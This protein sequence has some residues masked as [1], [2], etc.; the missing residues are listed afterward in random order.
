[1][2]SRIDSR[3][4]S[5]EGM[6]ALFGVHTYLHQHTDLTK[7]L[8]DLVFLRTSQINGCAHC[9][10]MHSRDLLK[11]GMTVDKLVLVPAWREAAEL[12]DETEKAALAWTES[13]TNVSSTHVPVED[14]E[15]ALATLSEKTLV[16]LTLA[17]G[18]M[19]AYNRLGVAFRLPPAAIHGRK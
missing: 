15:E 19:S 1:M 2:T 12:F 9:I 6:K 8:I 3:K 4:V 17:V 10:D 11:G 13:V 5:P 7:G 14:Y 16:D 18:L